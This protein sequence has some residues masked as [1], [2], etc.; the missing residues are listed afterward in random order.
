[1]RIN[2]VP[3]VFIHVLAHDFRRILRVGLESVALVAHRQLFLCRLRVLLRRDVAEVAHALEDVLLALLCARRVDDR[4]CRRGRFGQAGQHGGFR[5]GEFLHCFA[6]ID[7]CGAAEAVGTFAKKNLVHVKLEDL[8]FRQTVLDLE[9]EHDLVDLA[10]VCLLAAQI[11]RT[12]DLHRDGG[13]ALR[14]TAGQ[15]G[16]AGTQYAGI[17]D[18]AVFV[19]TVVLDCEQRVFHDR[20]HFGDRY[21]IPALLTEFT[22]QDMIGGIYA[23]RDLGTVIDQCIEI[24]QTR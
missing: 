15:V 8:V 20:R 7:A 6:E 11:E 24:R 4:V 18:T 12:R 17:I 10:A 9:G 16:Q 13:S 3:V 5:N 1:M 22:D 23:Q 21:K 19:E 2:V 14:A